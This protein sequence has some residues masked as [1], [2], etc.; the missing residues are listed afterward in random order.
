MVVAV[1]GRRPS[2][3]VTDPLVL[4]DDLR[5]VPASEL[6]AEL[7]RQA[8][9][10]DDDVVLTRP[11]ARS[12]SVAVDADTA[13]LLECFRQPRTVVEAILAY[14]GAHSADAEETLD[15]AY[16]TLQRLINARLLVPVGSDGHLRITPTLDRGERLLGHEVVRCVQ[17]LDDVEVYQ[18]RSPDGSP[19]ALKLLRPDASEA[20]RALLRHEMEILARLDGVVAPAL[21]ATCNHED[22]PGLVMEWCHGVDSSRAAS[23]LRRAAPPAGDRRALLRLCTAVTDAYGTLHTRD[24]LHGDI[25]PRNVL[26]DRDHEVRLV[27]FGLARRLD[28]PDEPAGSAGRGG[29]GF[30]FEPEL[31]RA[32]L[33]GQP[34]PAPSVTGEQFALGALLYLLL[35]GSHYAELA[36]D[37]RRAMRQIVE[38]RVR[39]FSALGLPAWP[40]VEAVL[41][42]ALAKDPRKRHASVATM[43][44]RLRDAAGSDRSEPAR[45]R[46]EAATATASFVREVIERLRLDGPLLEGEGLPPPHS[47]ITYGAGG[48]AYALYRLSCLESDPELLAL[49]D[50]WATVA[51]RPHDDGEAWLNEDFGVTS[52][53]VGEISPYHR[54]PGVLVVQALIGRAM[55]NRMVRDRALAAFVTGSQHP[56]ESDDLTLGRAGTLL[57]CAQLVEALANDD[58]PL[59]PVLELGRS[60]RDHLMGILADLSPV[61][62]CPELDYLGV[63]HGW[64]GILYSLLR[65]QAVT[66]GVVGSNLQR[67]LDELAACGEPIGRGLRWRAR[68][69]EVTEGSMYMAGWCNG[70]AGLVH[71]WEL[72][73]RLTGE[74]RY[75]VLAERAGWNAWEDGNRVPTLCCGLAG[76]AYALLVLHRALDEQRWLRYAEELALRAA[77]SGD[78]SFPDSLYKGRVG[79]ALLLAELAEPSLATM[80]MFASEGWSTTDAATGHSSRSA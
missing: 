76:R 60:V 74:E 31:A 47:S 50:V 56:C 43:A 36:L 3:A 4:P 22:R 68:T 34:L 24:V 30:L 11:H 72:T 37:E 12:A 1:S 52:D 63:A 41:A 71:L 58:A 54:R 23:E 28:R 45:P 15:S 53:R 6:T 55:G 32:W 40:E 66:G 5:L 57:A 46:P 20:V 9:C 2:T 78:G 33:E 14:A 27:D 17:L 13:A 48:I 62:D 80:P 77:R 19:L 69:L 65:W 35:T 67:R 21:V 18:L 44:A 10:T 7:R 39:P 8:R 79:V 70:S 59:G 73:H 75:L 38:Q 61:P 25:H 51:D 29:V 64:A 26:V 49:A 16:P 42:T